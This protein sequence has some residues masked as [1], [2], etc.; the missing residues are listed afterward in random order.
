MIVTDTRLYRE[1]GRHLKSMTAIMAYIT[2]G[3]QS[4]C[5]EF[6]EFLHLGGG[7]GAVRECY[8]IKACIEL[9]PM[10]FLGDNTVC[11][12]LMLCCSTD[13]QLICIS[14]YMLENVQ[15]SLQYSKHKL[16][17]LH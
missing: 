1:N 16:I 5:V 4:T 13:T 6:M 7:N 2:S 12:G 3:K 15:E 17:M 9:G 8:S 11:T 10:D 14:T